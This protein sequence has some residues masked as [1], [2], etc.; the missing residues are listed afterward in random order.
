MSADIIIPAGLKGDTVQLIIRNEDGTL[1]DL[2]VYSSILLNVFTADFTTNPVVN[3]EVK[4]F[5]N[6]QGEILYDPNAAL[7]TPGKFWITIERISTTTIVRP[8]SKFSLEV[9]Q[10]KT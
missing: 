8:A 6:N 10:Q 7:S 1:D 5:A 4:T 2:T 3:L 9:T